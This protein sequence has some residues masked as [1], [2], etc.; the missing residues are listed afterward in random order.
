MLYLEEY[1]RMRDIIERLEQCLDMK[2]A[3]IVEGFGV[4][5][6]LEK[7]AE[8]KKLRAAQPERPEHDEG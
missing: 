3:S 4:V 5:D 2:G 7:Y 8:C 1:D 6:A